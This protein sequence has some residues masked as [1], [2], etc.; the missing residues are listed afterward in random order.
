MVSSNLK[1]AIIDRKKEKKENIFYY[2]VMFFTNKIV[3]KGVAFSYF[4][5]EQMMDLRLQI[6]MH[7]KGLY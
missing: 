5:V 3:L 6:K 2:M 1:V 7:W 4:S